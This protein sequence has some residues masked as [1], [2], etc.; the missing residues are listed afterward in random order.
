MVADQKEEQKENICHL[1]FGCFHKG[2]KCDPLRVLVV[3]A[4]AITNVKKSS[5]IVNIA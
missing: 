1:L 3:P 4:F 2:V 5:T